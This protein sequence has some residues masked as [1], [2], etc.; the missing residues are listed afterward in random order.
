MKTQ[1]RERPIIK[2]TP[3]G[4]RLEV[5]PYIWGVM[6]GEPPFYL[7]DEEDA[8][9]IAK[10]LGWKADPR[11]HPTVEPI[12]DEEAMETEKFL[13]ECG[14]DVDEMNRILENGG[15]TLPG[16]NGKAKKN[17]GNKTQT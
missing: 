15:G 8:I 13:R 14:V 12:S 7:E 17:S 3:Q 16:W 10:K 6:H 11:W 4:E 1:S 5:S 2:Y 9:E